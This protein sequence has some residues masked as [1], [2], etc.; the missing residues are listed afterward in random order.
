MILYEPLQ[1][2]FVV[3]FNVGCILPEFLDAFMPD[4]VDF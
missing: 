2:S 3:L 1:L 4:V